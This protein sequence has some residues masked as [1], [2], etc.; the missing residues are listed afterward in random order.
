[1]HSV[2]TRL[3]WVKKLQL[4]WS[5]PYVVRRSEGNNLFIESEDLGF[6][7][8]VNVKRCIAFTPRT[9]PNETESKGVPASPPSVKSRH[10]DPPSNNA[11]EKL[12]KLKVALETQRRELGKRIASLNPKK[13]HPL[14]DL[15]KR[16]KKLVKK[17]KDKDV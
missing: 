7:G 1:M 10:Q 6:A 13:P 12:A 3:P 2:P 9:S 15:S 4:L 5:G 16:T 14:K 11:E 17:V 8:I